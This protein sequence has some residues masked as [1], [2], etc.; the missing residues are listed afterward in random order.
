MTLKQLHNPQ[1]WGN[2]QILEKEFCK[3]SFYISVDTL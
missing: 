3:E 1:K 2:S